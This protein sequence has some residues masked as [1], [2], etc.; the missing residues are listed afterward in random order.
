MT[1]VRIDKASA[2]LPQQDGIELDPQTGMFITSGAT[3]VSSGIQTPGQTSSSTVLSTLTTQTSS[4]P[5]GGIQ[6]SGQ[7]LETAGSSTI[8]DSEVTSV[9]DAG[10]RAMD[11]FSSA[12]AQAQIDLDSY[13]FIDEESL[14]N[15]GTVVMTPASEPVKGTSQQ[16]QQRVELVTPATASS[17]SANVS[18]LPNTDSK[19]KG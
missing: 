2:N 7:V 18:I 1:T 3:S 19:V 12:I 4:S 13:Q 10:S 15:Q 16:Q 5:L 14:L 17:A 9:D 8:P 6:V 11:I